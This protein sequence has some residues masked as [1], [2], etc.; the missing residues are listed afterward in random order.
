VACPEETVYV[1]KKKLPGKFPDPIHRPDE[2]P[3]GEALLSG[4]MGRDYVG[5]RPRLH[6]LNYLS[7]SNVSFKVYLAQSAV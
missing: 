5:T 1:V 3:Q 4:P 7:A 6:A 2:K